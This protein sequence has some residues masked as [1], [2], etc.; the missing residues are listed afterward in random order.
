MVVAMVV[1]SCVPAFWRAG[2]LAAVWVVGTG[3]FYVLM[4][5]GVLG[6]PYV[7][8]EKWGGLALTLFIFVATC[9]IGF[10]LSILL[11][12]LGRSV[13]ILE[14]Q[15]EPYPLPRAVHFDDEVGRILQSAGIGAHRN[16][17]EYRTV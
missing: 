15:P 9:L 1:I 3:L 5:G 6:L 16:P 7:G 10:P 13:T 17:L 8:E 4:R 12:Q 14:R 2:R 11:A